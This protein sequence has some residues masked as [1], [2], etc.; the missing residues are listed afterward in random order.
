VTPAQPVHVSRPV[1]ICP[2]ASSQ[3]GVPVTAY[4]SPAGVTFEGHHPTGSVI[5][6]ANGVPVAGSGVP[7]AINRFY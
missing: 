7:P 2:P 4:V 6:D 3:G 5:T 1:G